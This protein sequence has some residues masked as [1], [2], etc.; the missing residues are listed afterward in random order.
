MTSIILQLYYYKLFVFLIYSVAQLLVE[1]N[2]RLN[3]MYI[4]INLY[5]NFK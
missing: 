4:E 2:F 3:I 5:L 1:E